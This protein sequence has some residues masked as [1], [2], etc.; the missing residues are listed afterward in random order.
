MLRLA[1]KELTLEKAH[2]DNSKDHE[3]EHQDDSHVEDIWECIKESFHTDF[4]RLVLSN[5]SEDSK[6]PKHLK[7]SEIVR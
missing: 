5:Q 1:F 2:C 7:D 4:Q 3:E 6:D